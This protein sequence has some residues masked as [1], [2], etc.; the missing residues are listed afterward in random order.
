MV[1][2]AGR[3]LPFRRM[4]P[5]IFGRSSWASFARFL[6]LHHW[7]TAKANFFHGLFRREALR[8]RLKFRTTSPVVGVDHLVVLDVMTTGPARLIPE[9]T[10]ERSLKTPR[11]EMPRRWK[12][13][14][15]KRVWRYWT[16]RR[17]AERPPVHADIDRYT[18]RV[19]EM[20]RER[21]PGPA[22]WPL[23]AINRM[24]H[25]RIVSLF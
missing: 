6:W 20:I 2:P 15:R 14:R 11:D 13:F 16:A 23:H 9:V 12:N 17:S 3:P 10:W 22:G 5:R 19:R 25:W 21:W 7:S 18:A 1:D 24:N 4:G 8:G